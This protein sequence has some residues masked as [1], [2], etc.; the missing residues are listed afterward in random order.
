MKKLVKFGIAAMALATSTVALTS[1]NNT[2]ADYTIGVLQFG[3]FSALNDA[4]SGFK[5]GFE[6]KLPKDKSV[7][8]EVM[9][10][11]QDTV[12]QQTMATKLVREC[13]LVLGNA[14]PCAQQLVSTRE[15]EAKMN[16]PLLF[17]SVTDPIVAGLVSESNRNNNVTGTSDINP[18]VALVPI[19]LAPDLSNEIANIKDPITA[20]PEIKISNNKSI[21]T[22]SL[23]KS[24]F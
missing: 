11:N 4:T 19:A 17:T 22:S 10:A 13:D 8:F 21:Y 14:T 1:C 24:Y 20:P 15:I 2:K 3:D 9:N 12:A 16:L 5:A 18:V 23:F 7:K 6:A